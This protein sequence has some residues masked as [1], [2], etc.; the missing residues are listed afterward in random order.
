[1]TPIFFPTPEKFREW[2]KKNHDKETE[3]IVGFYKMST[4]KP[5]MTWSESVDQAL[6]FGWIDSVRKSID[7]ESYS[8]RFTPRKKSS[9]WS[10]INIKKVEELT[11]A[12]L[13]RE[14]GL[15]AFELRSDAK[16]GIYSYEKEPEILNPEFEK[17]FKVNKPAW[18]FFENQAPS[19]KKVM[20]HWIMSAKQE[21]TRLSRLEKAIAISAEQKRML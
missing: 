1:M 2:L 9:N 19:Y 18:N 6:C 11:K 15:K 10:A 13:M 16:S 17:Q 3:L 5:S 12:G 21:K 7:E 20:I 8:N 4:K 14:A